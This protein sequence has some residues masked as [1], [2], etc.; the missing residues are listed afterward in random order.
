MKTKLNFTNLSEMLQS[1][2]YQIYES[3]TLLNIQ[4]QIINGDP[5]LSIDDIIE[6]NDNGLF[7]HTHNE[8]I[9]CWIEFIDSL[10]V[11]ENKYN[12]YED[13][14]KFDITK[15]VY[16]RIKKDINNCY[17]YHLNHSTLNDVI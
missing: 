13:K 12:R 4:D 1:D 8:F 15:K 3:E 6:C 10:N 14:S 2:N 7:G 17:K 9:D 11:W 16:N 5:V